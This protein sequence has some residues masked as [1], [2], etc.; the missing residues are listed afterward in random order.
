LEFL[1]KE[2]KTSKTINWFQKNK[3]TMNSLMQDKRVAWERVYK[4][5]KAMEPGLPSRSLQELLSVAH[6]ATERVTSD[7]LRLHNEFWTSIAGDIFLKNA[8]GPLTQKTRMLF[9]QGKEAFKEGVLS[10]AGMLKK[11]D[12][13][14]TQSLQEVNDRFFEHFKE[15]FNQESNV[16]SD[17]WDKILPAQREQVP[18]MELP[19]SIDECRTALKQ[20]PDNK[21][22]GIS[23]I[24]IE[25][26][27]YGLSEYSLPVQCELFNTML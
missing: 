20:C 16:P 14:Q 9:G 2:Q 6:K 23:D 18:N 17:S 4:K 15:I 1:P 27:K 11:R 7:G 24:P 10:T 26:H 12:G 8:W 22:P 13:S 3:E 5:Q 25:G 19:F 21:T